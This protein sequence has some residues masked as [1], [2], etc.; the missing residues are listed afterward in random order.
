[1]RVMK[2][3]NRLQKLLDRQREAIQKH[4]RFVATRMDEGVSRQVEKVVKA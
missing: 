1:V 2:V 3:N 4:K